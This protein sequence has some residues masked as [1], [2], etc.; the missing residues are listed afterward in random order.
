[1]RMD[2]E[3]RELQERNPEY[4]QPADATAV[5]ANYGP[6][7]PL[8]ESGLVIGRFLPLHRG[9]EYLIEFAR[10]AVRNLTVVVFADEGDPID[11]RVRVKWIA[12]QYPGVRVEHVTSPLGRIPTPARDHKTAWKQLARAVEPFGRHHYLF[13]SE[14]PYAAAAEAIGAEFVPV[15]PA[16]VVVPISGTAIRASVMDH[17][18]Y[19]ARPARPWF[20][21]RVAVVGAECTG[22]TTLWA[23][24]RERFGC[25]A[26][27]EWTRTLVESGRPMT[28]ERVQLAARSQIA[29]ED[30][31]ATQLPADGTAGVLVCDTDLTT[32]RLWAER[33]YEVEVPGWIARAAERR[34]Y[35]LYLVCRPDFAFVGSPSRDQ[36]AKRQAMHQA[37]LDAHRRSPNVVEL[38]GAHPER[39]QRAADAIVEL[40]ASNA[41]CSLRGAKLHA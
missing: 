17:F 39:C 23:W 41:L 8:G 30:A 1:M 40:F 24:L 12:E 7:E 27:P 5:R 29:A 11:S 21:R 35:D 36:P 19:I 28:P 34:P 20:V 26:A 37:L 14:L 15:D 4:G 16:R 18:R 13:A 2:E 38:D 6:A 31:L 9:H 32:V 22:K 25:L 33:L 10:A 3:L